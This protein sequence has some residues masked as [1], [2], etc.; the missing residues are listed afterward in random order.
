MWEGWLNCRC[1]GKLLLRFVAPAEFLYGFWIPLNSPGWGMREAQALQAVLQDRGHQLLLS[2]S[3]HASYAVMCSG[4]KCPAQFIG[5]AAR[6]CKTHCHFSLAG[7]ICLPLS[8]G[9][10]NLERIPCPL[11]S[12]FFPCAC[13]LICNMSDRLSLWSQSRGLVTTP[14]QTPCLSALLFALAGR[15]KLS[16]CWIRSSSSCCSDLHALEMYVAKPLYGTFVKHALAVCKCMAFKQQSLYYQM[17]S[18]RLYSSGWKALGGEAGCDSEIWEPKQ[19]EI[20]AHVLELEQVKERWRMGK[21]IPLPRLEVLKEDRTEGRGRVGTRQQK[22]R[23]ASGPQFATFCLLPLMLCSPPPFPLTKFGQRSFAGFFVP[24]KSNHT[25]VGFVS[26][27]VFLISASRITILHWFLKELSLI[28]SPC[29]LYQHE[30]S[31]KERW[32]CC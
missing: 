28:I 12:S 18:C 16:L 21:P 23:L 30:P 10:G 24:W 11:L 32:Y 1:G 25:S 7:L 5:S 3:Q 13:F 26:D 8:H 2:P 6:L 15:G 31:P 19:K 20:L 14:A 27:D 9:T 4:D 17:Q 29:Y 22:S